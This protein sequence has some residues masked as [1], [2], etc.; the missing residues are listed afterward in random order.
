MGAKTT[1]TVSGL[2]NWKLKIR[3]DEKSVTIIRA[4]T[5]DTDAVL[6][7]EL[8]SLP[9]TEI[10][11]RA[12]MPGARDAEGEEV[13][14]VCGRAGD[15]WNN[16]NIQSLTLPSKLKTAGAYA[17][18]NC[19]GIKNLHLHDGIENLHSTA[20]INCRSF[21]TIDLIRCGET[22]GPTLAN[23]ISWFQRELDVTITLANG[24]KQRLIF[25]EYFESYEENGPTHFFNYLIEGTGFS[26]HNVCKNRMLQMKDYDG[27]WKKYLS[28]GYDED[29]ALRLAWWRI[30]FPAE[31][32]D[33][34]AAAYTEFVDARP[35][36]AFEL[37]LTSKDMDGLRMLLKNRSLSAQELERAQNRAREL[38][39]TEATAILLEEQH[40]RFSGGRRKSFEL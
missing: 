20:F 35:E 11:D 27:L 19:S 5:C 24:E 21:D 13:L 23:L 39:L 37:A 22:Q 2:S 29:T 10:S 32:S 7:D 28:M 6:P 4:L 9:V 17:F 34:D 15:E 31:L 26:Y 30:R 16:R 36:A 3:R 33:E 18:M 12:L 1:E 38:H 25:P 8:F 14:I 40:K